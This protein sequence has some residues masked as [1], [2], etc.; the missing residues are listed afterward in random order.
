M[1]NPLVAIP[2]QHMVNA[3]L[4]AMMEIKALAGA[5]E[6]IYLTQPTTI[7]VRLSCEATQE[8]IRQIQVALDAAAFMRSQT[9][10]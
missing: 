10:R 3:P 9:I 5:V 2:P 8:L 1:P 7:V 6:I 4:N